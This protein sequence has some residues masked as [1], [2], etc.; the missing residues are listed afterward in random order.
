MNIVGKYWGAL[1]AT[2][3]GPTTLPLRVDAEGRL[4]TA[5]GSGDA[6]NT[7]PLFT[8]SAN[9][10]PRGDQQ[11]T[12]ATLATKQNLTVPANA[13]V[14]LIQN[15]C[16]QAVRWRD[17]GPDPTAAV[18]QRIIPGGYLTYDG[19]LANFEVIIEAAG[20]GNL[21]IAYYS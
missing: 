12:A 8:K 14:A 11:I 17:F 7:S 13:R 18:G 21:D 4:M 10:T 1:W 6:S 16:S 15:N 2:L 9:Y 20:T 5:I 3:T 19:T